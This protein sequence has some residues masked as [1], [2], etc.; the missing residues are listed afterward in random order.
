MK[1]KKLKTDNNFDYYPLILRLW[2]EKFLILTFTLLALFFG[3]LKVQ[4]NQTFQK[5]KIAISSPPPN[6]FSHIEFG[7]SSKELELRLYNNLLSRDKLSNFLGNEEKLEFFKLEMFK[8]I[9]SQTYSNIF[10]LTYLSSIDGLN[11]LDEYIRHIQLI[12][13]KQEI[14]YIKTSINRILDKH[15]KQLEIAKKLGI[16]VPK[17]TLDSIIYSRLT[18]DSLSN[19]GS[20]SYPD[21]TYLSGT[22]VLTNKIAHFEKILNQL[23]EK[24]FI[25]DI[26]LDKAYNTNVLENY[27]TAN[28]ILWTVLGFLLSLV[29]IFIKYLIKDIKKHSKI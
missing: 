7:S 16:E 2:R 5:A 27:K 20:L 10:E 8:E 23:E 14:S 21:P 24:N 9:P 19:P 17:I 4:D 6:L 29:V 15:K 25:Y 12:T 26:I 13:I 1:N 18:L 11:L 22:I 3:Y 28:V